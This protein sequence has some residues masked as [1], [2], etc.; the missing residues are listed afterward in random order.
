[1]LQKLSYSSCKGIYFK[2]R[3]KIGNEYTNY[4]VTNKI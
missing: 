3:F 1:M 4:C 2:Q